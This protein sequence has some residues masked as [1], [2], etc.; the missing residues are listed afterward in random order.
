M[1]GVGSDYIFF[2]SSAC[3]STALVEIVGTPNTSAKKPYAEDHRHSEKMKSHELDLI[4][5]EID[6]YL[7]TAE[8]DLA[9][10]LL[11]PI[12]GEGEN[13]NSNLFRRHKAFRDTN[14][15]TQFHL[16]L[17]DFTSPQEIGR[18][19]DFSP[20]MINAN[21]QQGTGESWQPGFVCVSGF[22]SPAGALV[23]RGDVVL[24]EEDEKGGENT[25]GLEH[26]MSS[27]L[28]A[29][30]ASVP[31][32]T[33]VEFSLPSDASGQVWALPVVDG[34]AGEDEDVVRGK[35]GAR[36]RKASEQDLLGAAARAAG[37]AKGREGGG[38]LDFRERVH[39][40]ECMQLS[41]VFSFRSTIRI[42]S[43]CFRVRGFQG[44]RLVWVS[45]QLWANA[46]TNNLASSQMSV[47]VRIAQWSPGI[48]LASRPAELQLS[49]S[50]RST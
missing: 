30:H 41:N 14:I 43:S 28:H 2:S 8:R 33:R 20:V 47:P 42:G 6:T 24:G 22:A 23:N 7:P 3:A 25:G 5:A 17:V 4:H 26:G 45:R 31:L 36:K 16:Q 9:K 48:M 15:S 12:C 44:L 50:T 11:F 35:E 49:H 1:I 29:L 32:E 21:N 34:A 18:I 40:L 13:T 46:R 38:R 19:R 10:A 37:G 27:A 39:E